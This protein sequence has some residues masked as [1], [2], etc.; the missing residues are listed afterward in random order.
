MAHFWKNCKK[1]KNEVTGTISTLLVISS[2]M[3][4]FVAHTSRTRFYSSIVGKLNISAIYKSI[5]LFFSVN[6]PLFLYLSMFHNPKYL[7]I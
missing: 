2:L 5:I 4:I 3:K 6:L 7:E 1:V